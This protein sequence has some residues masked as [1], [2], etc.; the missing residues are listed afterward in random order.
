MRN[1]RFFASVALAFWWSSFLTLS[2]GK[3]DKLGWW[4]SFILIIPGIW[5]VR[6]SPAWWYSGSVLV[7]LA[8]GRVYTNAWLNAHHL[9][10]GSLLDDM[11]WIFLA[12]G[13]FLILGEISKLRGRRSE[14]PIQGAEPRSHGEL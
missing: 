11:V 3:H 6:S 2:E 1:L 4:L 10:S 8:A 5:L 7:S 13:L 9:R 14:N 12:L